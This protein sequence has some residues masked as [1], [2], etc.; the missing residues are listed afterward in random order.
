DPT[1]R[2][3]R[4]VVISPPFLSH[5][6]PMSVF[7]HALRRAGAETTVA[8]GPD[9]AHLAE[10]AGVGF[11]ELSVTRNANTGIAERTT[12]AAG[13][14]ARLTEFLDA[15]RNGA[16][17][18][19]LAQARHRRA[20]LL[21][22]PD[23]VRE[24]IAALHAR[25]RPD[26]YVVDLLAYSA[27]LALHCLDLPHV[28]FC[29]G[30]PGYLPPDDTA[31]FGMPAVW[32][33]AIRPDRAELE[34]LRDA[35]IGNDRAFT[36]LFAGVVRRVAPHRPVPHR[37]FALCS[38]HAVV[39][40]YPD[41]PWLPALPPGAGEA[42]RIGHCAGLAEHPAAGE[43]L[44]A[45]WEERLASIGAGPGGRPLVL[46]ALGTFLSA[47]DDVLRAAARGIL[48]HC[49]EAAVVVAAGNRAGALRPLLDPGG[50]GGGRLL[51]ADSVPQRALLGRARAMVHHGG[52]NSFTECLWAGVPAV[53]LPFS[54]DQFAVAHDAERAG[55]G[56]APG[57]APHG[58]AAGHPG[59]R[60]APGR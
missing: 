41:L 29:P 34:R 3:P 51:V 4:V 18:A 54:S 39:L 40:N 31:W 28:T 30:H 53:V 14:A 24:R 20:D 10:E 45:A 22:D 1:G 2:R 36:E 13:E 11:A 56:G 43:P 46:V 50:S 33:R 6:R 60:T 17:S 23:G 8:C 55:A 26:W 42:V 9:F 49:P 27:T 15:T 7:A 48:A 12:Q 35:V 38:P 5:A 19:L 21:A 58:R 52:N 16:V 44:S 47:R 59:G 32:P 57:A 37:A 25:L